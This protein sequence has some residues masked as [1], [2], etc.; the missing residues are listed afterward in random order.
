MPFPGVSVAVNTVF[1]SQKD[2]LLSGLL[3]PLTRTG[4]NR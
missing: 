1:R 4:A 3:L 2:L